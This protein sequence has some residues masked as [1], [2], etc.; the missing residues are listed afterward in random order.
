MLT[1]DFKAAV[2]S[3]ATTPG[4]IPH[5][6]PMDDTT[7]DKWLGTPSSAPATESAD[8]VDAPEKTTMTLEDNPVSNYGRSI[9]DA[10]ADPIKEAATKVLQDIHGTDGSLKSGLSKGVDIAG[11]IAGGVAKSFGG[12]FNAAVVKPVSNA[13]SESPTLQHDAA[14]PNNPVSKTLDATEH[15]QQF[16]TDKWNQFSTNHPEEAKKIADAGN[17]AQ[18]MALFIGDN[19]KVQET[20]GEGMAKVSESAQNTKNAVVDATKSAQGKIGE[21]QARGEL[22]SARV[23]K[24]KAA[25]Q[26]K[27]VADD[28]QKPATVNKPAFN[29]ARA[30]LE[31][32]PDT[33]KFLAEH[34][35][36]PLEHL[37]NGQYV[38]SDSAQALRDTAGKM[39]GDTLRPSLQMAD[40]T[41]PK[42]PI[43][44]IEKRA[45]ET[46]GKDSE[47]TAADKNAVIKAIKSEA[48]ALKEEHPDGVG[49][50][51]MHDNKITYSKN[52]GYSPI[53]DPAANIKATANRSISSVFQRLI[54]EK[55]PAD[56][57]VRD[58]NAHLSQ[59]Y[60]AADYLDAINGKTAPVSALQKVVRG[61]AKFGGAALGG[62]FGGGVVSEFAGYQIGKALEAALENMTN[63]M[64]AT[65]LRN[66]KVTNPEAFSKVSEYISQQEAEAAGRPLLNAGE[67]GF[68]NPIPLGPK[69]GESSV[70]IVPAKK[71]PV[72][73]NPKTGKFQTSYSSQ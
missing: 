12:I 39:S 44:E 14:N 33:P 27:S 30:V 29:K 61:A 35:L 24:E 65:F 55:A 41:T 46:V 16:L 8:P 50:T 6:Q 15:A 22:E 49:L 67:E 20:V 1:P 7:F 58:F 17:I 69:T 57:P 53:K 48:E 11:D 52:A 31:K 21:M 18:F 66:L 25:S 10:G 34:G 45:I 13:I 63:P 3:G 60:K 56:V 59:F 70:K 54:E 19:P 4:A 64:R 71:N 28:W 32:S 43:A 38:T 26:I 68:K 47:T 40:Y 23:A 51:D 62:H 2:R 36:N 9:L 42:T 5:N 37:E 72:S 73:V